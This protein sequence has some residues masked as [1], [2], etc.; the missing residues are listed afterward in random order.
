MYTRSD[1]II[2]AS[3]SARNLD[4]LEVGH[5]EYTFF[6]NKKLPEQVEYA[7]EEY[8]NRYI[9]TFLAV[10]FL[11]PKLKHEFHV[12]RKGYVKLLGRVLTNPKTCRMKK[13][14]VILTFLGKIHA[15]KLTRKYFPELLV[16]QMRLQSM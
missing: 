7:L 3:Y 4:L 8:T 9:T 16:R 14:I 10:E 2:N 15:Y 11:N 5:I 1:S 12:R 13:I 6:H